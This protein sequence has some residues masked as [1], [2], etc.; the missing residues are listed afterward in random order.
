MK[1]LNGASGKCLNSISGC[2]DVSNHDLKARKVY[3]EIDERIPVIVTGIKSQH[4]LLIM[5]LEVNKISLSVL[6]I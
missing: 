1:L 6:L 5:Y 3:T 4:K 2:I